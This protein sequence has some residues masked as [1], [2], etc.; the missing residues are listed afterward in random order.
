MKITRTALLRE[1]VGRGV[2]VTVTFGADGMREIGGASSQNMLRLPVPLRDGQCMLLF[3]GLTELRRKNGLHV[4][5]R[6]A[7]AGCVR[8]EAVML[9]TMVMFA[10]QRDNDRDSYDDDGLVVSFAFLVVVARVLL[11]L[12]LWAGRKKEIRLA[13][14]RGRSRNF[15]V[16]GLG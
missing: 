3:S 5:R 14:G 2:M 6:E 13:L 8:E 11:L 16:S 4:Q 7:E 1:E 9:K 10:A 12:L 15:P